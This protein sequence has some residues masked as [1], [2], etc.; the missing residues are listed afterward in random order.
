MIT[1]GI[2]CG[3][4]NTRAV[5]MQD[6]KVIEKTWVPT[7]F[8]ASK[9]ANIVYQ[10]AL[11]EAG[12]E[13]DDVACIA[14]TGTGRSIV[15]LDKVMINE[16]GSA[17]K[18]ARFVNPQTRLVIDMGADSSRVVKL[19]EDGRVEKYEVN[20]KCASGAG[21]FIETMARALQIPVEE[22]GAASLKHTKEITTNAQCV[23][24]AESE[25]ISLIH[26]QETVEDI[27]YGIHVGIVN[28]ISSLIRRVGM[29]DHITLIGGPGH[30][31][32]LL[33]CMEKE[34]GKDIFVSEETDYISAIGAA[35]FAAQ[36]VLT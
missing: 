26:Q 22:M 29:T 16:V 5:V 18:G 34:F 7:E 31:L 27:A 9:A 14:V 1:V 24:F 23:V 30:N 25:V 2:D 13:S 17:V 15:E 11:K 3:S 19:T 28:R 35:I 4:Q 10:R 6:G 32:G 12:I 20:D 36:K 33:K 21:T 8:D